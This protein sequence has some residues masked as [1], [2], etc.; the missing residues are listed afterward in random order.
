[1]PLFLLCLFPLGDVQRQQKNHKQRSASFMNDAQCGHTVNLHQYA[2]G[3][4]GHKIHHAHDDLKRRNLPFL[5]GLERKGNHDRQTRNRNSDI[6]QEEDALLMRDSND[7][8]YRIDLTRLDPKSMK[9]I[10]SYI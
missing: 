5:A 3:D 8:R 1:M 7:N 4:D 9:K 6:K 2:A 10:L